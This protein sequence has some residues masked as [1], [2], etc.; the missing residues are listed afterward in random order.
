VTLSNAFETHSIVLDTSA[1]RATAD[2]YLLELNTGATLD[3]EG[4][5]LGAEFESLKIEEQP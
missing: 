5:I 4:R 1:L 3:G 2:G